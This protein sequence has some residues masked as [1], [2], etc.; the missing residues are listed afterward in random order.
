MK[1]Y[2]TTEISEMGEAGWYPLQVL[3]GDDPACGDDWGDWHPVEVKWD[4]D[5]D[6]PYLV[7]NPS[8]RT[9]FYRMP[10]KDEHRY[11]WGPRIKMPDERAELRKGKVHARWSKRKDDLEIRMPAG[12]A[13]AGLIAYQLAPMLDG[14]DARGYD[15]TTFRFSIAPKKGTSNGNE[16]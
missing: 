9:Y 10:E 16:V 6:E 4:I 11:R 2:T 7:V 14:L 5:M 1:T 3:E 15:L 12:G 13:P 8:Y